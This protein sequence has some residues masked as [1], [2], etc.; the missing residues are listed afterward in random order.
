MPQREDDRPFSGGGSLNTQSHFAE[1]DEAV[2]AY[3]KFQ[4]ECLRLIKPA[5]VRKEIEEGILEY[6]KECQGMAR[7]MQMLGEHLRQTPLVSAVC[8]WYRGVATDSFRRE[9]YGAVVLRLVQSGTI[10]THDS[11]GTPVT[12]D[13]LQ[14]NG[15]ENIVEEIRCLRGWSE[16][17]KELAIEAYL[18]FAHGI[19][20]ATYGIVP[21]ALDPIRR[22]TT[23][24]ALSYDQFV[25]LI[26]HLSTRDVLIAQVL[27][28]GAEGIAEVL[29]LRW[30]SLDFK[31]NRIHFDGYDAAM[32]KHVLQAL[33]AYGAAGHKP[34]EPVFQ[35]ATGGSVDRSTL[36][37][38]LARASMKAGLSEKVTPGLL[39]QDRK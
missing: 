5:V 26:Q 4:G 14:H 18:T 21:Y 24:K 38:I 9:R 15:H 29:D 2:T 31:R 35:N 25:R 32:P 22:A 17:D 16:A 20:Q 30:S 10:P 33:E 7:S 12:V 37:A 3:E 34:T 39:I 13:F 36:T 1:A 28:F 6:R 8:D 27:Y 23:N 19:N 11:A